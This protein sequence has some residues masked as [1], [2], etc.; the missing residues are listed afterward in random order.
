MFLR[1]S[2]TDSLELTG[3]GCTLPAESPVA[4]L[5]IAERTESTQSCVSRYI[6]P[7]YI[8]LAGPQELLLS[9]VASYHGL[10]ISV[11][12][13]RCRR[14]YYRAPWTEG[15]AEIDPVNRGRTTSRNGRA[16]TVDVIA[17][18]CR[19]QASVGGHHSGG[20]ERRLS[21]D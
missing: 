11:A 2:S 5:N 10:T 13:I 19:E 20:T 9:S 1:P 17:P 14:S 16:S 4:I 21:F 8:K 3:R 15:V 6:P 7:L 12:M 18:R